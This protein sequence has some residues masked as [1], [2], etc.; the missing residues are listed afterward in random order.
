MRLRTLTQISEAGRV[1]EIEDITRK[2][3]PDTF[4]KVTRAIQGVVHASETLSLD[5][6]LDS[7][8]LIE[9]LLVAIGA[10][11]SRGEAVVYD[12]AKAAS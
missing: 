8:K 1:A 7:S 3:G 9:R 4:D 11:P 12:A 6:S 5:S 2:L 10:V